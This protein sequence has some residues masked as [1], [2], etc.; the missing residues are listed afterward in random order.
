MSHSASCGTF[1]RWR[2]LV[3]D[4]IWPVYV[5]EHRPSAR[6]RGVNVPSRHRGPAFKAASAEWGESSPL[7]SEAGMKVTTFKTIS[8]PNSQSAASGPPAPVT[9]PQK[10]LWEEGC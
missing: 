7:T 4:T 10:T 1:S 9:V 8:C 3:D 5:R 6:P 2:R